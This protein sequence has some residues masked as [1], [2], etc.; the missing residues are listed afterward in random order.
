MPETTIT[1]Q[2][3]RAAIEAA[4]HLDDTAIPDPPGAC[5]LLTAALERRSL[6][7]VSVVGG[8]NGGGVSAGRSLLTVSDTDG[9]VVTIAGDDQLSDPGPL[10]RQH[11]WQR[12]H[13]MTFAPR[14]LAIKTISA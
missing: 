8:T 7:V 14:A 9:I 2:I 5:R 4:G 1:D 10:L 13:V 6:V 3:Y 12:A 11:R